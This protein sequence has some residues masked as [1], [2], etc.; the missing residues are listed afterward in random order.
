MYCIPT[1]IFKMTLLPTVVHRPSS[2]RREGPSSFI[3]TTELVEI[4]S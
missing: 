2:L 1:Y 4:F 3:L